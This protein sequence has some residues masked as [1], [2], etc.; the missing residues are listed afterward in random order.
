[1]ADAD[2]PNKIDDS[3]S[4]ADGD[5]HAPNAHALVEQPANRKEKP[6]QDQEADRHAQKPAPHDWAAQHNRTDF[7][8]DGAKRVPRLNDRS[9]LLADFDFRGLR[10][11]KSALS[12]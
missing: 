2:P 11:E 5:V 1:M 4:P 6:L 8:G 7:V 12:F 3:E 10:H 9:F